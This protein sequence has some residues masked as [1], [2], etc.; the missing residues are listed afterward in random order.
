M[1]TCCVT[2]PLGSLPPHQGLF[3][4]TRSREHWGPSLG[5]QMAVLEGTVASLSLLWVRGGARRGFEA[6]ARLGEV[7]V[8]NGG[9]A[10]VG[11]WIGMRKAQNVLVCGEEVSRGRQEGVWGSIAGSVFKAG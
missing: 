1:V 9:G 4:G 6:G 11:A 2:R 10:G 5:P 8:T 7:G 3:I